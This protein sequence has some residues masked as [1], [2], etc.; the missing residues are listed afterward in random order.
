MP[1][2]LYKGQ[3]LT[4]LVSTKI[5]DKINKTIPNVPVT[6]PLKYNTPII[7]AIITLIILS[8]VPMFFFI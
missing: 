5:I 1:K 3:K 7:A 4:K 2:G 8:A 6:V